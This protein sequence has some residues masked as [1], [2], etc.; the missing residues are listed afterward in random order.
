MAFR[1]AA[2]L[3]TGCGH[4]AEGQ[5][6]LDRVLEAWNRRQPVLGCT[7]KNQTE[8]RPLLGRALEELWQPD[9]GLVLEVQWQLLLCLELETRQPTDHRHRSLA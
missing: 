3:K 6:L 4:V 5:C 8:W 7:L 1:G 9:Q 2:E